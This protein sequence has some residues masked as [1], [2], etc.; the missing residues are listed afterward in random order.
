MASPKLALAF[1]LLS[2]VAAAQVPP[3]A[4]PPPPPL[5]SG[6]AEVS[7]VSTSGNT[8]TQTL[9]AA[10]EGEYKPSPWAYK[11]AFAF[12]RAESDGEVKARSLAASLRAGRKIADPIEVFAEARYLKNTFAGVDNRYA[13]DAGIAWTFLKMP[14]HTLKAEV[15]GG[16]TK[17]DRTTGDNLSFATAR[18]GLGYKWAISKTAEFTDDCSFIEDLSDTSDWR[19]QSVSALSAAVSTLFSLKASYT[20][21]YVRKPPAGFGRTDTI[22]AFA[23]VAKF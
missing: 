2:P 12:V 1:A 8:S 4:P 9:G 19:T 6:K 18:V 10:L 17:E 5:Y 7:F 21:A 13:A 20:F 11:A 22:T 15:A 23:L 3:P 16:Y 14:Q